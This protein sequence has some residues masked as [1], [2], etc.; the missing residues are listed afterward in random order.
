MAHRHSPA[1]VG[2][3]GLVW[4]AAARADA[5]GVNKDLAANA[6]L[7]YWQAINAMPKFDVEKQKLLDDWKDGQ[8]PPELHKQFTSQNGFLRLL[9]R[10][11][12]QPRCEWAVGYEDGEN[13]LFTHLFDGRMLAK[14][15]CWRARA[16]FEAGQ[17][18]AG[19]DD[20]IAALTLARHLGSDPLFLSIFFQY[21]V[22]NFVIDEVAPYLTKMDSAA[23][24]DLAARLE[25][26]PQ[27]SSLKATIRVEKEHFLPWFTRKLEAVDKDKPDEFLKLLVSFVGT[28]DQEDSKKEVIEF[29][30]QPPSR[31]KVF[32]AFEAMAPYYDYAAELMDTPWTEWR[33]MVLTS[34]QELQKGNAANPL[35]R[36]DVRFANVRPANPLMRLTPALG[37][38]RLREART[39][40]RWA[41]LKA[42]IAVV[43][44]GPEKLKD[45]PD[46][47]GDGPFEYRR[48]ENGFELESKIKGYKV[49]PWGPNFTPTLTVGQRK[50]E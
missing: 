39:K 34:D 1:L 40:A 41:M 16:R 13:A 5:P 22:E 9:H 37:V 26:L 33:A 3:L 6:A 25:A 31:E 32:K 19:V 38:A 18:Q 36:T 46:P 21:Q 24:K 23:L 45:H 44:G 8:P 42:A 7:Y 2:V 27:G 49:E 20:I 29:A 10:G 35:I 4:L 14:W 43:Q 12:R 30:G 17:Y 11:A 48:L 28:P 15:A 47:Y 50:K